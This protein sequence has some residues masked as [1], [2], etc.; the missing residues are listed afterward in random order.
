MGSHRLAYAIEADA[1]LVRID[2]SDSRT[3]PPIGTVPA[4]ADRK[5]S[6]TA[7]QSVRY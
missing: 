4:A 2:E 1:D 3:H 5:G 7:G 6:V